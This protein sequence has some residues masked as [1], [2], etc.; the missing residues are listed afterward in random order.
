MFIAPYEYVHSSDYTVA[1][2]NK[3]VSYI[4]DVPGMTGSR[5]DSILDGATPTPQE[6][7]RCRDAVVQAFQAARDLIEDGKKL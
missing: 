5:L 3:I 4:L 2:K 1:L 7:V 6:L